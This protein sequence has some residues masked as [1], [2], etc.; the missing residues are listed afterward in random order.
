M[1]SNQM[2]WGAIAIVLAIGIGTFFTFYKVYVVETVGQCN[3]D[4]CCTKQVGET[5]FLNT[6][7]GECLIAKEEFVRI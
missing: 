1:N 3:S 5:A 4:A 6:D 2:K 7:T